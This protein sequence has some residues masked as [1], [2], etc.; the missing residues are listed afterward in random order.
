MPR[1]R[2]L[3]LRAPDASPDLVAPFGRD[4]GATRVRR[5]GARDPRLPLPWLPLPWLL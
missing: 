1:G 2:I 3:T 4:E 5:A